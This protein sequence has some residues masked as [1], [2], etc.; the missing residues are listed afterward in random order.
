MLTRSLSHLVPRSRTMIKMKWLS[1]RSLSASPHRNAK[2]F[3]Q[4]LDITSS[5]FTH[6]AAISKLGQMLDEPIMQMISNDECPLPGLKEAIALNSSSPFPHLLI[7]LHYLR[8]SLFSS[9]RNDPLLEDSLKALHSL[10]DSGSTAF[11]DREIL[12]FEAIEFWMSGYYSTAASKFEEVV[13]SHSSDLLAMKLAQDAYMM[14]GDSSNALFCSIRSSFAFNKKHILHGYYLGVLCNGYLD[15]GRLPEAEDVGVRAV[16]KCQGTDLASLQALMSTYLL[17]GRSSE[18]NAL[19]DRYAERHENSYAAVYCLFFRA[20]VFIQRGNYTGTLRKLEEILIALDGVEQDPDLLSLPTMLVWEVYLNS[21]TTDLTTPWYK[22][23]SRWNDLV[24]NRDVVLFPAHCVCA[25]IAFSGGRHY[26][27]QPPEEEQALPTQETKPTS[28][29]GSLWKTLGQPHQPPRLEKVSEHAGNQ[30]VASVVIDETLVAS[31]KTF[32]E[33]LRATS[34]DGKSRLQQALRNSSRV[35]EAPDDCSE[36]TWLVRS[37][38]LPVCTAIE[39]FM[40]GNYAASYSLLSDSRCIWS[41]IGG[42]RLLRDLLLLT[43]IEASLRMESFQTARKLLC[44]RTAL[45]P[46]DSHAWRRLA[47]A[48]IR[49]GSDEEAREA[50]YTA[51]Q[52]GIGQGGFG[53]P[54]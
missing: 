3:V 12:Y 52:L 43:L 13:V 50:Q 25:A 21:T 42:S 19:L 18:C 46:N 35:P 11:N 16:D 9:S 2:G 15:D 20:K 27:F 30:G 34:D 29:L 23:M 8:R 41:R 26:K 6:A 7:V 49:L 1:S 39:Q 14:A 38:A 31:S 48:L 37:A 53:G 28:L 4:S 44:E 45:V 36:R 10:N 47:T 32:F 33:N 24:N 54:K 40:Q 51:W 5:P 17:L 22:L